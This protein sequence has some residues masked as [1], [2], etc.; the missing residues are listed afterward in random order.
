[1]TVMWC[2]SSFSCYL[3]N[4]MNKYL[5]GSIYQNHYIEGLAGI[6][7]CFI[8]IQ[9]YSKLG[10]RISFLVAFGLAFIGGITIFG[11][12]ADIINPP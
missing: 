4:F 3:L 5:E 9:L 1:M 10:K 2:A 6:V 8:G 7:A 11:L 12:E